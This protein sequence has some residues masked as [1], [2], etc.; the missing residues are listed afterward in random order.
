MSPGEWKIIYGLK[1]LTIFVEPNMVIPLSIKQR[2]TAVKQKYHFFHFKKG[3]LFNIYAIILVIILI[4][5]TTSFCA[6]D[7]ELNEMIPYKEKTIFSTWY[8]YMNDTRHTGQ[9]QFS[10][11]NNIGTLQWKYNYKENIAYSPVMDKD[12][13]I[14][15]TFNGMCRNASSI[16]RNGSLNWIYSPNKKIIIS[17]TPAID[18]DGHF[19]AC[20]FNYTSLDYKNSSLYAF[21]RDGTI[22]WEFRA[23]GFFSASPIV[24]EKGIIY[25]AST[26]Q[27][28]YSIY[29]NGKMKWSFQFSGS[30]T[31][32]ISPASDY[33]GN[34]IFQT[35]SR[36]PD[37][38]GYLY[39]IDQNGT[40]KWK[41]PGNFSGTPSINSKGEIYTYY[42]HNYLMAINNDGTEKWR[43]R[44][45][46]ITSSPAIDSFDNIYASTPNAVIKFDKN[47]SEIWTYS[48]SDMILTPVTIS[49]EGTIYFGSA[50]GY[51]YAIDKDGNKKWDFATGD[52]I[53]GNPII[54][55]EGNIY[56]GSNDGYFYCLGEKYPS[57]PQDLK[58]S[59]RDERVNLTWH[60]P[61][62]N[63][64]K[65]ID[66][67]KIFRKDSGSMDFTLITEVDGSNLSYSDTDVTNG[68]RYTYYITARNFFGESFPSNVVEG[69]PKSVPDPP[70]QLRLKAGDDFIEI[71]WEPPLYTG[72]IDLLSS[73]I[74]KSMN[75]IDF[76]LLVLV[77]IKYSKYN[78]TD[79][80]I[81]LEYHYY[82][83]A[84]NDVGESVHSE[85]VQGMP[86]SPPGPPINFSIDGGPTFI[87]LKW[88]PPLINGGLPV[89]GFNV[90]RNG[91]FDDMYLFKVVDNSTLSFNDTE[92]ELGLMYSYNI[93][94]FNVKGMSLPTETLS[95]IPLSVP[96][97]PMDLKVVSRESELE[98][99][100]VLSDLDGGTDILRYDIYRGYSPSSIEYYRSGG[101]T[102]NLFVDRTVDNGVEYFYYLRAVNK[103]GPS[104]QSNI[105]SGMPRTVSSSPLN[106]SG[107]SGDRFVQLFW[108]PPLDLRGS[109]IERY[110]IYRT[111]GT[112]DPEM[113]IETSDLVL[114]FNDTNVV[115]G[116][117]YRYHI[118]AFCS[119]FNL[120]RESSKSNEVSFVPV[121]RPS[122]P[123]DLIVEHRR[124]T[125]VLIWSGP[126]DDG[127]TDI[128]GYHIYR[129][130]LSDNSV[131]KIPI[132]SPYVLSFVDRELEHRTTYTYWLT[133]FNGAG[134][135]G[136]GDPITVVSFG[137]PGP[138]LNVTATV[139]SGKVVLRWEPVISDWEGARIV[140]TIYRGDTADTMESLTTVVNETQFFD[141][142]VKK[143]RTYLY[144]IVAT[145]DIGDSEWSDIVNISIP[146]KKS[147][148]DNLL[149]VIIGTII[150][151]SLSMVL[152]IVFIKTRKKD[153][154]EE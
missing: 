116:V 114:S 67:Y 133:S 134:E 62:L 5:N 2:I 93:R 139:E 14:F 32:P 109:M 8:M 60:P 22:D 66:S 17:H 36:Q 48:T 151:T 43:L 127:G 101:P 96:S 70:T 83:T 11:E 65:P 145:D 121:G 13:N 20:S 138:P 108:E 123:K 34:I 27:N 154:S 68:I 58:G 73:K 91:S 63:G 152:I 3:M 136:P 119:F 98:L 50:G 19:L 84:K 10:T 150:F 92:V 25:T 16:N 39:S 46:I 72:G 89:G 7:I 86:L 44:L 82:V 141:G 23:D 128:L 142:I 28:F 49:K 45:S 100:W 57:P 129:Q 80:E 41:F 144:A 130:K 126:E 95:F 42:E 153:L 12:G 103:A 117:E 76:E 137:P 54:D 143:D 64:G 21:N 6:I 47:G 78:D 26:N 149:L 31:S 51:L 55:S 146:E 135:S 30:L 53:Q 77:P 56:F 118:T 115:N 33:D 74:Y 120:S 107:S 131:R 102:S 4:S 97:A 104:Q 35:I 24:D 111:E 148:T 112:L 38:K 106:L 71:S 110:R 87:E 85:I 69:M 94:S 1:S 125:F 52:S 124:N 9:S 88:E 15:L 79:V 122:P 61:L 140:Y 90:Y 113:L 105:A 40:L 99:N 81:G 59:F 75:G 18:H 147:D 132:G 37:Y 29:P